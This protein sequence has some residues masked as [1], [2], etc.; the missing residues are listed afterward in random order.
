[1]ETKA[2]WRPS[3]SLYSFIMQCAGRAEEG[4]KL[5][6]ITAFNLEAPGIGE[7]DPIITAYS[8]NFS[9]GIYDIEVK[10]RP[11]F[12]KPEGGLAGLVAEGIKRFGGSAICFSVKRSKTDGRLDE[13]AL[14]IRRE[15]IVPYAPPVRYEIESNG[16]DKTEVL[17]FKRLL[18]IFGAHYTLEQD[19]IDVEKYA[20]AGRSPGWIGTAWMYACNCGL[21]PRINSVNPVGTKR[22]IIEHNSLAEIR[23][24]SMI[25]PLK[26]DDIKGI[27]DYLSGLGRMPKGSLWTVS[28]EYAVPKKKKQKAPEKPVKNRIRIIGPEREREDTAE[29]LLEALKK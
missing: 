18:T 13:K 4:R 24:G 28:Y 8:K 16:I 19:K 15:K 2:W 5:E 29:R 26:E 20:P 12:P 25:G 10:I 21:V 3:D 6:R 23:K 27:E 22:I 11:T 1:M 17:I 7:F 9:R 14:T